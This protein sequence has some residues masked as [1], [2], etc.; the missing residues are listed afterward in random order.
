MRCTWCKE[1]AACGE[2]QH[3]AAEDQRA[4]LRVGAVRP[5]LALGH[6][7]ARAAAPAYCWP[8]TQIPTT[9]PYPTTCD[10]HCSNT[11]CPTAKLPSLSTKLLTSFLL[12]SWKQNPGLLWSC[13]SPT[14]WKPHSTKPRDFKHPHFT[15]RSSPTKHHQ[16]PPNPSLLLTI[17][18]PTTPPPKKHESAETCSTP[19]FSAMHQRHPPG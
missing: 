16:A 19:P 3:G 18:G 7:L 5:P 1:R 10:D 13:C 12:A 8:A 17:T 4:L 6:H 2:A 9:A 11:N 14:P 15:T